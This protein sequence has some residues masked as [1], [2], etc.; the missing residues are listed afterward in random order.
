MSCRACTSPHREE[1]DRRL[2][3]GETS[4]QVAEWL[5]S[6]GEVLS[7]VAV[8]SHKKKH[9]DLVR[10]AKKQIAVAVQD[11]QGS[12]LPIDGS[13]VFQQAVQKVVADVGMLDEL[14]GISINIARRFYEEL[15]KTMPQ[16]TVFTAALREARQCVVARHELLNGKHVKLESDLGELLALAFSAPDA[17]GDAPDDDRTTGAG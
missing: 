8:A 9:L 10:E 3:A 4:R 14:A 6:Q 15:P 1:I 5:A 11:T 7:H 2:L 12:P 16:A 13:V 17:N